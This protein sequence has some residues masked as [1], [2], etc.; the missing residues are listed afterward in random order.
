MNSQ[1]SGSSAS[2]VAFDRLHPAVQRWIWK[3]GWSS[4]RSIQEKAIG[5]ILAQQRDVIIAAATAGGKTEAAFLPVISRCIDGQGNGF[6]ALYVSPLKALINDQARRLEDLCD[7][8][9]LDL[10]PWHGDISASVKN[11]A[12]RNPGGLVLITPESLEAMFVRRG[13]QIGTLFSS[14]NYI[15]IDELHAFIGT[16]RGIQLLSLLSRLEHVLKRQVVRIGLSATLGDMGIAAEALRAN[17]EV[18]P[19]I[20][21]DDAAGSE[22]LVQVRGYQRH[23]PDSEDNDGWEIENHLLKTLR[24]ESNLI[25][26]GS[27]QRVEVMADRLRRISGEKGVPNEFFPHHGNLSKELREALEKRLKDGNLPTNAIATTTL[28]LGIDIGDV[29]SVAQIGAPRSIA[30][31]RQRL[32]RSGRRGDAP[33]ILR[34]YAEEAPLTAKSPIADR[35]RQDTVMSV[36]AI[37]L[38]VRKWCEAPRNGALHL[39]TLTHQVLA[40][41]KQ[42]GGMSAPALYWQLCIKGEFRNVDEGLF[43]RLLRQMGSEDARLLEQ[44]DDG[45]LLLGEVGERIADRYDFYVVFQTPEEYRVES[46][47]RT[48]GQISANSQLVPEQYVIFAGRRWQV[49]DV[50]SEAKVVRVIPAAGGIPPTFDGIGVEEISDGLV[51][52]MR[53][54]YQDSA[55]APYCDPAGR[56][57]LEEG[58]KAYAS[59]NLHRFD[60]LFEDRQSYLFP[61]LGSRRQTT[62][63]HWLNMFD[64]IIAEA[65]GVAIGVR[66][67]LG[68]LQHALAEMAACGPPDHMNLAYRIKMKKSQKY[69]EYLSDELLD[70]ELARDFFD[71]EGLQEVVKTIRSGC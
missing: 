45:A 63:C 27:R 41:I 52:E 39:S 20:V 31:L 49:E 62:L 30:G 42:Y 67:D 37:R 44:A 21:L 5:P 12:I 54:V 14:L 68:D 6:R 50:D 34:I 59:A 53:A 29:V 26:A 17:K 46:G 66:A 16:E 22:L 40:L 35:L 28:E 64:G 38:L 70:H 24:G 10:T 48:L 13:S 65:E 60:A 1:D 11:R 25:F 4:L 23:N 18:S 7:Q 8:A 58:R 3:Q 71:S 51:A 2:S 36:A 33:S 32:G 47:G 56:Q 69:H 9:D 19:E 61:W 57:F 55:P 15:V 43:V